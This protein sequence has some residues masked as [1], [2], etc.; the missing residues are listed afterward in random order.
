M[1]KP[2]T[3]DPADKV[4]ALSHVLRC[5]DAVCAGRPGDSR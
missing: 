2:V 5:N 3:F 1:S 4:V